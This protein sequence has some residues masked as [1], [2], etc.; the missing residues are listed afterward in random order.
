MGELESF[1]D[2]TN[3]HLTL[4][5]NTISHSK[6]TV[7]TCFY[8]PWSFTF[9]ISVLLK[10]IFKLS[11]L[12]M[13]F[14]IYKTVIFCIC[15]SARQWNYI[16]IVWSS[17]KSWQTRYSLWRNYSSSWWPISDR[18][19]C[20]TKDV[21]SSG[22]YKGISEVIK[23][24]LKYMFTKNRTLFLI[25]AFSRPTKKKKLCK[26]EYIRQNERRTQCWNQTKI[27]DLRHLLST[28]IGN[29]TSYCHQIL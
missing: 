5:N 2:L 21:L 13:L 20:S 26:R 24:V 3:M 29:N 1:Y 12:K 27:S 28:T 8:L 23:Y 4:T 10:N 22:L 14:R 25:S 11:C 19:W 15:I 7:L 16:C 6:I 18:H 9:W 17:P